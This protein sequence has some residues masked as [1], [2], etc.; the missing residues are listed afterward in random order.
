MMSIL[1]S[2]AL[3]PFHHAPH[4]TNSHR[5]GVE[6]IEWPENPLLHIHCA[7][8]DSHFLLHHLAIESSFLIPRLSFSPC[9]PSVFTLSPVS[10]CP[11][12]PL[13]Q[14]SRDWRRSTT[15]S[16]T[17]PWLKAGPTTLCSA[18]WSNT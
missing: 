1:L 18:W 6:V 4:A 10:L 8:T 16:K 11:L 7:L 3:F 9:L 17:G 2:F 14:T 15:A 13:Q 12:I 5:H